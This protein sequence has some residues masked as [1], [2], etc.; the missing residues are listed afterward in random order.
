MKYLLLFFCLCGFINSNA[1][2]TTDKQ[3]VEDSLSKEELQRAKELYLQMMASETYML[4]EKSVKNEF[5]KLNGL[6]LP[7][8][9]ELNWVT[10]SVAFKKWLANNIH[11]TKFTSVDEAFD[12]IMGSV[13]LNMKRQ[14]ENKELFALLKK[15][16]LSQFE[17]IIRPEREQ[18]KKRIFSGQ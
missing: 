3:P 1:Q 2:T 15:T 17:E 12:T 18:R 5:E 14:E 7:S 11:Q 10:D 13:N 9:K 8:I 4:R 6:M 16:T